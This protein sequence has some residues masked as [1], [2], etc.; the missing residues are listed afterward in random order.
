MNAPAPASA[1]F[2]F[3]ALIGDAVGYWEP[4]R[5]AYNALLLAVVLATRLVEIGEG[6]RPLSFE[7]LQQLFLLAV[8]A[9]VAYCASY[10]ADLFFQSSP[11]RDAWRRVRWGLLL[12][13][14]VKPWGGLMR[15]QMSIVLPR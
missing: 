12:A 9:N 14:I 2:D 11:F 4:R 1:A 7:L 8:L 3:R 15:A 10:P 5:L 13:R 6:A